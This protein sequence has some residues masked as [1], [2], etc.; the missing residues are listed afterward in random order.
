MTF[1][2]I[3]GL[4]RVEDALAAVKAG[5]DAIGLVLAESP[6]RVI[7]AEAR[8]IA[9]AVHTARRRVKVT[10]VFVN[11]EVDE[12]N[13]LAEECG[14]DWIQLSGEEG[15]R[16]CRSLNR[17]A[18]KAVHVRPGATVKDL[19][20]EI[21]AGGP[22]VAGGKVTVLLDTYGGTRGG[23]TGRVFD[24]SLAEALAR[25]FPLMLAGGLSPANVQGLVERVRPWGVDVSSGV[26]TDGHKDKDKIISFIE[27]VRR[28]DARLKGADHGSS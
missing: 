23:G 5:A 9:F 21:N 28:V 4:S 10:G 3:C 17:R 26:E 14:L 13:R 22:L 7:P 1:I 25:E 6:R 8:A 18:L 19:R 16:E 27:A 24:W 12:V 11:T 2:K 20:L 15:W